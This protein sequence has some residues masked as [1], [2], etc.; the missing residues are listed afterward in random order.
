MLNRIKIL[1]FN[2]KTEEIF[3]Q[4]KCSKVFAWP[5][6]NF[7][8]TK[9]NDRQSKQ[10]FET[11]LK[12]KTDQIACLYAGLLLHDDNIPIN[13]SFPL[14]YSLRKKT[15]KPFLRLLE[16]KLNHTGLLFLLII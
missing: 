7:L 2:F 16:L 10:F 3:N 4:L 1:F 13:V 12:K 14:S 8:E 6:R 5:I 11:K 9:N 15:L